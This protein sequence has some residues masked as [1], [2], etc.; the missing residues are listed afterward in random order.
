MLRGTL[1]VLQSNDRDLA[2][3]LRKMDDV[4]DELYTA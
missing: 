4:V 2:Q 1:K 3:R